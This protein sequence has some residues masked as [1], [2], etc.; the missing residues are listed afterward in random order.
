MGKR[1]PGDQR[2]KDPL[3]LPTS[4]KIETKL[5]AKG[6]RKSFSH[7]S[8]KL[9][10]IVASFYWW[11]K[12]NSWEKWEQKHVLSRNKSTQGWG[13]NQSS[14]RFIYKSMQWIF[15]S[16][17]QTFTW[18]QLRRFWARTPGAGLGF[19][20][21]AAH[22][23][24]MSIQG[25]GKQNPLK[26]VKNPLYPPCK[27][28]RRKQELEVDQFVLDSGVLNPPGHKPSPTSLS[29]K[30]HVIFRQVRK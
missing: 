19:T 24:G 2:R 9:R 1:V 3:F 15:L 27:L 4:L 10:S 7:N 22:T 29:L 30:P 11:M 17:L 26:K 5:Q 28:Y 6:C 23:P 21:G 8:G 12:R 14:S 13:C 16:L 25:S 20:G 18:S